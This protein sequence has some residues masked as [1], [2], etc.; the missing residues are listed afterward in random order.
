MCDY[1]DQYDEPETK[2]VK[3]KKV[4]KGPKRTYAARFDRWGGDRI[5]V[6]RAR[7][8]PEFNQHDGLIS[9][10]DLDDYSIITPKM[11]K[12]LTGLKLPKK[13][14]VIALELASV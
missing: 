2:P 3:E 10:D 14:K 5:A 11:F 7:V 8:E 9:V 1:N 13:G 12:A 4:K 6:G